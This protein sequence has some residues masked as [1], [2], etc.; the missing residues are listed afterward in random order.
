MLQMGT[1]YLSIHRLPFKEFEFIPKLFPLYLNQWKLDQIKLRK[2][3]GDFPFQ[4]SPL[5]N[6]YQCPDK[7]GEPMYSLH[8]GKETISFDIPQEIEVDWITYQQE[9]L[10]SFN[11]LNNA[12]KTPIGSVPLYKAAKGK[13]SAVIIISDISRLCPSS[14]FLG[15]LI[16][17]LN[18]AGI[19]DDKIKIIVALGMH[20]KQT[21]DEL[22]QLV[23]SDIYQRVNVLNHSPLSEDCVLMGTT[24]RGTPLEINK[25]VVEADFRIVTGNLEPHALAGVSGGLKAIVPGTAS[26][27]C[28]EHNHAL[29][30]KYKPTIGEA[31]NV[32]RQDLEEIL[33]FIAIHFMLNVIVNHNQQL[34]GAVA[35]HPITAHRKGLELVKD[36]FLIKVNQ[37]YDV[38]I[39]SP[40]GYPKDTQLYQSIKAF[41]NASTITKPGGKIIGVASC[42]EG[43]GN[44]L[45]QYWV[46][47]I[48]D[49]KVMTTKLKEKFV[50]GAHKISH[51]D[52]ILQQHQVFLYSKL[53][54]SAVELLGFQPILDLQQTVN[55]LMA[56]PSLQAA[57]LP[58]GGLTFPQL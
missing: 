23:G 52:E 53:P 38:V 20:R 19:I 9:P 27:R 28:I 55:E 13:Q 8:Y 54:L 4:Q 39:V 7:E 42:E 46:E 30:Q 51:V 45:F 25:H 18:I 14:L 11:C 40:G 48:Q 33:N 5:C 35:G 57:I 43:F 41:R 29:S 16:H 31:N 47:T 3:P 15:Q 49:R 26:Y 56:K 1:S 6:N 10:A 12:L 34:L 22:I 17:E 58:F 32:I 36:T 21:T 44:G 37:L 50:L 24:S 2:V